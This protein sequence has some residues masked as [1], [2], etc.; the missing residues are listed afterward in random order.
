MLPS[1]DD[2]TNASRYKYSIVICH[3]GTILKFSVGSN[4]DI[5]R[6]DVILDMMQPRF[7][8]EDDLSNDLSMLDS[9]GV[10]MEV[11]R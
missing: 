10:F 7:D 6:A 5:E 8:A 11:I 4:V 3:D 9:L 2:L 1:L